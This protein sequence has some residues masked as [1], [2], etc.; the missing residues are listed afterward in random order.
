MD[1]LTARKFL[2]RT[3]NSPRTPKKN[4]LS[5]LAQRGGYNWSSSHTL[6]IPNSPL[7]SRKETKANQQQD[8]KSA[9]NSP[10]T[11][12]SNNVKD[13]LRPRPRSLS[14]DRMNNED[15]L[16]ERV[17]LLP[18]QTHFDGNLPPQ[19]HFDGNLPPQTHF[20]GNFAPIEGKNGNSSN[21][22]GQKDCHVEMEE[23]TS[24]IV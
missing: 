19:T 10:V 12:R 18:P 1:Q 23:L 14:E 5:T 9:Q 8:N 3:R 15:D 2:S 6:N 16:F 22:N 4:M 7:V 21:G 24:A 13:L 17:S 20:D 11:Q